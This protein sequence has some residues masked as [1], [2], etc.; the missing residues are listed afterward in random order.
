MNDN[1]HCSAHGICC[2]CALMRACAGDFIPYMHYVVH[3]WPLACDVRV[4]HSC[5]ASQVLDPLGPCT[6]FYVCRSSS[7]SSVAATPRLKGRTCCS[8]S[9]RIRTNHAHRSA[10]GSLAVCDHHI[11]ITLDFSAPLAAAAVQ[12]AG[13]LLV[14]MGPGVG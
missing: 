10:W 13:L 14:L 1:V 4:L 3:L 12:Q 2:P 5:C 6:F 9:A 7:A 11:L 8:R